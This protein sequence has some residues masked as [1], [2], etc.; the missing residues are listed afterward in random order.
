MRLSV[1]APEK[2]L[3]DRKPVRQIQ[4]PSVRGELG[5]LPGHAALITL[6]QAGVLRYL[7]KDS[8][9]WQRLAVGWGYLEISPPKNG[10]T[11][12]RVLAESAETKETLDR[13][14]AELALKAAEKELARRDLEP[15]GRERLAR[16]RLRLKSELEI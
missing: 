9:G 1:F 5:I 16:E 6:L 4:A 14:K 3:L 13:A 12:V 8:P 15:A 10:E 11:E 7:P 2:A